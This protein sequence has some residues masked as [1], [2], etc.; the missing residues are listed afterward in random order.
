MRLEY[1]ELHT[2]YVIFILLSFGSVNS[3]P[4]ILATYVVLKSRYFTFF[5]SQ[6]TKLMK[7]E[8]PTMV[9]QSFS[10][11]STIKTGMLNS[12]FF[13]LKFKLCS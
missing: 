1:N 2:S 7:L 11:L 9:L 10:W 8:H 4:L 6:E 12:F 3:T 13:L 5:V